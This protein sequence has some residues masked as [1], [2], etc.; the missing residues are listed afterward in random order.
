MQQDFDYDSLNEDGK[1][2]YDMWAYALEQSESRVPYL[3]HGNIF[4]RG[5]PHAGIPSFLISYQSLESATDIEAYL[6]R[7]GEIDRVF[8]ELLERSKQASAA[9]IRQPRFAYDS[10]LSE[11]ERVTAGVPFNASDDSPNPPLPHA[12]SNHCLHRGLG[13]VCGMVS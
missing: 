3:N 1:L 9:G 5:G 12:V 2:S 6:S 8:A 13:I 7:L 11:I 4:G 10:A